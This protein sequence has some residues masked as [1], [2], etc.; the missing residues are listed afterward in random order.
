MLFNQDLDYDELK[1]QSNSQHQQS[2]IRYA[3]DNYKNYNKDGFKYYPVYSPVLYLT[4]NYDNFLK[5]KNDIENII[6]INLSTIGKIKFEYEKS[7]SHNY[8]LMNNIHSI[9]EGEEINVIII[10]N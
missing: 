2:N 1:Y 5:F 8:K 9:I 3:Y 6:N 7:S 10:P 4:E